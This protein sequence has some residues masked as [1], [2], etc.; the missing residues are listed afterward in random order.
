MTRQLGLE[1][2]PVQLR[3]DVMAMSR[4]VA[5]TL[6]LIFGVS[7]LFAQSQP[8]T[9]NVTFTTVDVPGAGVTGVYGI[10]S[11]GDMVGYYGTSSDDPNKHGFLYSGGSFTYLD[12][13]GAYSTFA[14]GI[15]DSA[16][17]VGSSE[18]DGGLAAVG[19]TYNGNSYTTIQDGSNSSTVTYAISNTGAIAGGSGTIYTTKGIEVRG[20]KF[21]NLSV[22]GTYVYIFASGINK[23]GT[24]VGWADEDGF[25]CRGLTC[26]IVDVPGAT[27][28]A[29]RG[30]SDQG[31]VVGW[32]FSS[33]CTCA[34][35]LKNGR[36]FSF[37]YP[38]AAATFADAINSSGQVVGQYTIDYQTF[39]GFVTDPLF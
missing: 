35:A 10:N 36:Y 14:F 37:S 16:L 11:A 20:S 13:P 31:I 22:P 7:F 28:T 15:N 9:L 19:F 1:G 8:E 29:N 25:I 3:E 5:C 21:K 39:H 30:I 4:I 17:I 33:S 34:F 27:Q 26:R 18:T 12:Y 38:G 23:F 2:D 24:L 32:Y 6:V